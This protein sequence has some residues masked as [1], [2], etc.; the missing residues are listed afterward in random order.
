MFFGGVMCWVPPPRPINCAT[1]ASQRAGVNPTNLTGSSA[2][3][4]FNVFVYIIKNKLVNC[5]VQC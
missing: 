1:L 5:A 2:V 3:S 4:L